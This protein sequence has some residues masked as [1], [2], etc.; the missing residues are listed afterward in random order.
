MRGFFA[1]GCTADA[2]WAPSVSDAE[3]GTT[4]ERA[5]ERD[6]RSVL[7][8]ARLREPGWRTG[9]LLLE[10]G[11]GEGTWIQKAGEAA[12]GADMARRARARKKGA[13]ITAALFFGAAFVFFAP[14]S[15]G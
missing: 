14:F 13:K 12:G 5:E 15:K 1:T 11:E 4:L 6:E 10:E 2:L 9:V 7:D 8:A 3:S